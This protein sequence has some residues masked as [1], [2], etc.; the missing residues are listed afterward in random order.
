MGTMWLGR[1]RG[2]PAEK[3]AVA[4]ANKDG[5]FYVKDYRP[6]YQQARMF[7][8]KEV[9]RTGKPARIQKGAKYKLVYLVKEN[10]QVV[11]TRL[12]NEEEFEKLTVPAPGY[13]P[14]APKEICKPIHKC[15]HRMPLAEVLQLS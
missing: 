12:V 6:T 2:R 13:V 3:F 4:V 1:W 8:A 15:Q 10:D 5:D 14:G 7:A 9:L 11:E